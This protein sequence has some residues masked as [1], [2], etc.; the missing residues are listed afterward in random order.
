M[1]SFYGNLLEL[2]PLSA[3]AY[4][5]LMFDFKNEGATFDELVEKFKVSKSSM[6]NS[7]QSLVQNKF[8]E[9]VTP[10]DS[11]KRLYRINPKYMGIR[12]GNI[13]DKLTREKDL[14]ERLVQCQKQTKPVPEPA[15]K[16]INTYISILDRHIKTIDNTVKIL[17][18]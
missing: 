18:K 11:R 2:A 8:I 6:S 12:F 16:D 17:H 14:M 13:L 7:L 4:V 9:F 15:I 10:I 5:Y 1:V 3:K